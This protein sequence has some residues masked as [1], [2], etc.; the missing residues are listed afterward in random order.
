MKINF[1]NYIILL[2]ST[3]M[4]FANSRVAFSRPTTI[5]RTPS[6]NILDE[7]KTPYLFT[8]GF[9]TET[10]NLDLPSLSTSLYLHTQTGNGFNMGL[11]YTSLA[12]PRSKTDIDADSTSSYVLPTE[13]GL[14]MQKRIYQAGNIHIDLGIS[15]IMARKWNGKSEFQSPSVYAV[16]SSHKVFDKFAITYNFGFGSGKVALDQHTLDFDQK[17]SSTIGYFLGFNLLTPEIPKLKNRLNLLFELDGTSIN[18]GAKLPITDEYVVSMGVVHFSDMGDFGNRSKVGQTDA[19]ISPDA[20]TICFGF[21]MN[22]PKLNK[23]RL[24][25]NPYYSSGDPNQIIY[26]EEA[27]NELLDSLNNIINTTQQGYDMIAD[28]IKF[29]TF[30]LENNEIENTSLQQKIAILED[31]LYQHRHQK[32]IDISNYNKASRH[33]S[34]ALRY[35]YE[36]DYNTALIEIDKAI[37]INP[38]L[39]IAYARKGTIYYSIGQI[40]SASINWNIALKLDPEYDEVRDILEALKDNKLKSADLEEGN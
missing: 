13:I 3:T 31:S 35:Y 11:S 12:D 38:N 1:I 15:D 2:L 18:L 8:A 24:S 17:E 36:Q 21:E 7:E 4:L 22:V 27:V 34:R 32:T 5:L 23:R 9:S 28:S 25:G 37:E 33:I 14:H 10:V 16:F 39:A 29:L 20:S 19:A 6:V 40:Q 30:S 26:T